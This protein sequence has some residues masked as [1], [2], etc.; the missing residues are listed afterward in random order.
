MGLHDRKAPQM[1]VR[2][3]TWTEQEERR[4]VWWGIV[5]LD[6]FINIGHRGKPFATLEPSIDTHLPTDDAAWDRGQMLAA[7][8]LSLSASQT[9]R[10]SP[11]ARTCQAAH[12]LGKAL[13]HIDDRQIPLDY[14]FSEALQLKRTLLALADVLPDEANFCSPGDAEKIEDMDERLKAAPCT[15]IGITYSALLTLYD[16]YSCTERAAA[17]ELQDAGETQL[18]MQKECIDGLADVSERAF[19][20]AR[21]IKRVIQAKGVDVL[22]PMVVDCIYQAAANCKSNSSSTLVTTCTDE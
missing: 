16:T 21:K 20:F 22:S 10:V 15:S 12:L 6:R 5:V 18:Q 4:R 9:I 2:C 14:R 3:N 13:R 8:P 1:L 19:T 7:A 17:S 11:F